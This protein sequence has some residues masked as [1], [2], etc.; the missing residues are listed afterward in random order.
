MKTILSNQTADI[1]ENVNITLK[2]CT[3]I[4]KSP[5]GTSQQDFNHITVEL[6]LLGKKKKRLQLT[7]GTGY[8]HTICSHVQNMIKGF[9]LGFPYK[10]KFVY[11]HFPINIVIEENGSVVEIEILGVKMYPQDMRLGVACSVSQMQEDELLLEGND[12]ELI[13]SSA[14]LIQQATPIKNMDTRKILDGISVSEKEI[15]QHT[16]K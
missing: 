10:I 1:P 7:N 3:V 12:N 2:G 11:A 8:I 15:T 9:T 6:I 5:R 4:V 16:D 14:T 13:L